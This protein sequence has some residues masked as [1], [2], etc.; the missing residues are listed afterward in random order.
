M[1]AF[2]LAIFCQK[3]VDYLLEVLNGKKDMIPESKNDV[4]FKRNVKVAIVLIKLFATRNEEPDFERLYKDYDFLRK[5]GFGEFYS[6]TSQLGGK[7]WGDFAK[8]HGENLESFI[9]KLRSFLEVG[10]KEKQEIIYCIKFFSM[11][12]TRCLWAFERM[13]R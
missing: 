3:M 1:W 13:L 10:P 2:S 6:E 11:L 5:N 4:E 12:Q 7:A 9:G 8:E